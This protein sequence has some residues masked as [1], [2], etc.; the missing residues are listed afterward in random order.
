MAPGIITKEKKM[1]TLW[2][3]KKLLELLTSEEQKDG[4]ILFRAKYIFQRDIEAQ[5]EQSKQENPEPRTWTGYF[6]GVEKEGSIIYPEW[7]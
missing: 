1:E 2:D 6:R 4:T 5:K 3:G 7:G